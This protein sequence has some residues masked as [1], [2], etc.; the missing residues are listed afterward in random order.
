MRTA[1]LAVTLVSLGC[2]STPPPD[3]VTMEE[4]IQLAEGGADN[5]ALVQ[6]LEYR[7]LGFPLTFRSLKELEDRG[8]PAPIFFNDTATTVNRRARA[9]APYYYGPGWYY[10]YPYPYHW[11]VGVGHRHYR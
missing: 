2:A 4:I 11:G 7:P 8:V 10:P 5:P 1:L 9:L 6:A 3:P